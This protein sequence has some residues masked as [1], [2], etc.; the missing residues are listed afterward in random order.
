[1]ELDKN[2]SYKFPFEKLEIW[3]LSVEFA[4]QVYKLTGDFPQSEKFGITNQLRRAA[5]SVSANIA[6]GSGRLSIKDKANFFQISY[7]SLLEVLN[8]LIISEKLGFLPSQ[9]LENLR[10]KISE[11]SNKINAYYKKLRPLPPNNSTP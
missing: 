7:S 2:I 9:E 5:N 4:V 8:F 3:T 6:E 11:L 10:L 1:M